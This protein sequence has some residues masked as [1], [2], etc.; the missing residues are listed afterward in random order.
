M[1]IRLEATSNRGSFKLFRLDNLIC[2]L[3]STGL[4]ICG[5]ITEYND[6]K[7]EIKA[8]SIFQRSFDILKDGN[9]VGTITM[10]RFQDI[11]ITLKRADGA[12]P[13]KFMI[14][15]SGFFKM[16]YE[17][18]ASSQR[19]LIITSKF[20]WFNFRYEYTVEEHSHDYPDEVLNEL[21]IYAG[22]AASLNHSRARSS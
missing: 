22:F 2:N 19:L 17:L 1:T 13:D 10:H 3:R 8:K 21:L 6:Q 7:I 15:R 20:N 18:L 14:K 12:D 11:H 9:G 16:R 5:A 4:I